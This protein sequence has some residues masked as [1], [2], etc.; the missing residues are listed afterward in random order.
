MSNINELQSLIL[1]ALPH[2]QDSQDRDLLLNL[3]REVADEFSQLRETCKECEQSRVVAEESRDNL[4][5]QIDKIHHIVL[6]SE[7]NTPATFSVAGKV[8][9]LVDEHRALTAQLKT[10]QDTVAELTQLEPGIYSVSPCP[11][12]VPEF[13]LLA[14]GELHQ[15]YVDAAALRDAIRNAI[16]AQGIALPTAAASDSPVELL[17]AALEQLNRNAAVHQ[18]ISMQCYKSEVSEWTE[19]LA[20][21]LQAALDADF[22]D[23]DAVI[24]GL[25]RQLAKGV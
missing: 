14:P 10:Y 23:K 24:R 7:A 17:T 18:A 1:K 4:T 12:K 11:S 5:A 16:A 13:T 3:T 21:M 20:F 25:I 19:R 6:G 2:Y 22:G 8:Q 15:D 9:S